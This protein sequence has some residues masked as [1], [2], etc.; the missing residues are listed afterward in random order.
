MQTVESAIERQSCSIQQ[1][2]N[3]IFCGDALSLITQFPDQCID[4]IITSPPFFRQRLYNVPS[5]IGREATVQEYVQKL[6]SLFEECKRVLKSTGS[7]WV[8]MGDKLNT[9][10]KTKTGGG[11]KIVKRLAKKSFLMIPER[12]VIAMSDAGWCVR[13][14]VINYTPN[15]MPDSAGDRFGIDYTNFYWFVKNESNYYFEPQYDQISEETLRET[16]NTNWTPNKAYKEN[17]VQSPLDIKKRIVRNIKFGGNKAQGYDKATYSGN[18][19][20]IESSNAVKLTEEG[21]KNAMRMGWDGV[22]NYAQWYFEEREKKSWHDHSE[23]AT[24][25]YGQQTR[26][27][28]PLKLQFPYGRVKRSVWRIPHG[29]SKENH[30]AAFSERLVTTPLLATCPKGGIILDPFVGTGTT[31]ITAL[32]HYRNYVGIDA[33]QDYCD[34]AKR[35]LRTELMKQTINLER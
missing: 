13:N 32:K 22:S 21:V 24:K 7:I 9:D 11:G 15:A 12:F 25:G 6:V 17:G 27:Q 20:N 31:C 10:S 35:R 3:N 4:S 26:H 8:E 2:R 28:K 16:T 23:D 19:W 18:I 1:I 34:T 14:K 29:S 5:E 33:S 30:F